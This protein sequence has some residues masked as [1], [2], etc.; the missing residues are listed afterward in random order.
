MIAPSLTQFLISHVSIRSIWSSGIWIIDK[1][2]TDYSITVFCC[3]KSCLQSPG[4]ALFC[5]LLGQSVCLDLYR[6]NDTPAWNPGVANRSE[7][8]GSNVIA[9]SIRKIV[10]FLLVLYASWKYSNEASYGLSE[11]SSILDDNKCMS[12]V[13][14]IQNSRTFNFF[15]SFV[16]RE[17]L[18]TFINWNSSIVFT[19]VRIVRSD[20]N[21]WRIKMLDKRDVQI[22]KPAIHKINK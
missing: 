19:D 8:F 16:S 10:F 1:S 21:E 5:I 12:S 20:E 6:A 4:V 18:F 17:S 13:R 15:L 22:E 11:A 7:W 3:R 9:I 14:S 2:I